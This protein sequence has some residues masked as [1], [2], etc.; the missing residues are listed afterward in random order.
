VRDWYTDLFF[1]KKKTFRARVGQSKVPY[2]FENLQS[3]QN[4]LPLDR[5]DA[6][7]SAVKDER[8]LGIFLYWAPAHIRDRFKYLVDN[9][10]KGSGDYGVVGLGAYNGQTAN[11]PAL[12]DN[13]H[14]VLRV[15]WPFLFG[16]QFVEVGAG[17]YYGQYRINTSDSA[18]VEYTK[19][20]GLNQRDARAIASVVVYPQPFGFQ[21]E[22]TYGVGPAQGKPGAEDR[23]EIEERKVYGGYAQIM[24][25]IDKPW[26]T[27]SLTPFARATYYDGGKKFETNVP[28][29]HVKEL[30]LGLEWQLLKALELTVAYD[31]ADRTSSR[32][33]Y[34]RE[35]GQ[36][37]R[38][39]LQVNY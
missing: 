19:P 17:G 28:H 5:N 8:D 35:K 34:Y 31:F 7:N 18:G 33:P 1:D 21:A 13:M 11:R 2:G 6:I 4:R 38:V 30:E 25:M 39:Q 15:T 29:Y 36:I 23:T 16:E 27:I 37:W 9:N 32:A 22:G 14:G 20:D 3:S 10:L 12:E 24:Y 26:H